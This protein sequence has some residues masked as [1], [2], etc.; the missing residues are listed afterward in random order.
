MESE[1]DKRMSHWSKENF[2]RMLNNGIPSEK[3]ER[4]I[5]RE[6]KCN[7]FCGCGAIEDNHNCAK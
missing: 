5:K 1:D 7:L 6:S 4:V 2:E 3:I